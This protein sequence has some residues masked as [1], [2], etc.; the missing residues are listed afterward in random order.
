MDGFKILFLLLF[1]AAV[2]IGWPIAIIWAL[3]VLFPTA[4]IPVTLE[5]WAAVFI[6]MIALQNG[7]SYMKSK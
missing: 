2:V 4:A 5:T 1:V 3:N 6:I 7:I